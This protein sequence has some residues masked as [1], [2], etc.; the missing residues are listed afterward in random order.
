M[1]KAAIIAETRFNYAVFTYIS[2]IP[3]WDKA[4]KFAF[5]SGLV[6]RTS[7]WR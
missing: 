1:D 7:V 2:T 5:L 4:Y 6:W 3:L